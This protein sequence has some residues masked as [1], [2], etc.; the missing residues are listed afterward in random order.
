MA[1]PTVGILSMQRVINYGSFLQSY[2]LKQLLLR[3]GAGEVYFVDIIPGKILINDSTVTR[4][5]YSRYVNKITSLTKSGNLISGLKTYWFNRKL[6]KSIR[7]SWP[8][9][10]LE[11]S[12]S[13]PFDHIIIGS[14]EVFNC[15]Q[16]VYWGY[17]T[18]LFGNIPVS[19]AHK[20]SSYAGSFGY[21]DLEKLRMYN[22]DTEVGENLNKLSAISV[23]DE[24]SAIIVKT[25]TGR[26]PL[27][28]LDPVLAYG[29]KQ[30]I[31]NFVKSPM[32]LPYMIVYSYQ[33]RINDT[34]E[35]N[36][37]TDFAKKKG[38]KLISIFCR[39]DWCD[40]AIL[41]NSPIDV[42]QW[43]KFANCIVTDTFHGTI[44]SIITE[45]KFAT[46]IR[47]SN[48]N[49]LDYL[50]NSLN[51]SKHE[52]DIT[53]LHS[54]LTVAPDYTTCNSILEQKRKETTEYLRQLLCSK[55]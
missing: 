48:Y 37:I 35:I 6:E 40:K 49:K 16:D 20:V 50:L 32:D 25:L 28:H 41:P 34:K 43:F 11:H 3:N 18:Q 45:S 39:Y 27:I 51:L 44:F 9:L 19:I 42:L 22:I 46:I 26:T 10:G 54:V 36:A 8:M 5:K 29:Y 33:D 17:T 13:N 53:S 2:A 23:R 31:A 30:E 47:T 52:T 1:K 4:C 24:N 38:L 15:T 21:T 7:K 14:D 12:C 55:Y